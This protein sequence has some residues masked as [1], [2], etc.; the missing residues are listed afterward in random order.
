MR[1]LIR[2]EA[3]LEAG[4]R[5]DRSPGGPGAAIGRILELLKPETF[6]VSVF[7]REV[8]MIVNSDDAAMLTEATHLIQLVGGANPEVTAVLSSQDTMAILP[9]AVA[10]A[11]AGATSLGL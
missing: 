1:Y 3:S 2:F 4:A 7:R 9:Q 11:V 6:Y 8:F 10:R 5:V